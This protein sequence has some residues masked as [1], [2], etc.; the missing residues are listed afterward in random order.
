MVLF[1]IKKKIYNFLEFKLTAIK[2]RSLYVYIIQTNVI[3][4]KNYL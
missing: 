2:H 3:S 4:I 1:N